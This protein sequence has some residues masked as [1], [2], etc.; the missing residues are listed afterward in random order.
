[1]GSGVSGNRTHMWRGGTQHDSQVGSSLSLNRR[2]SCDSDA[3]F[4]LSFCTSSL[5]PLA[6]GANI[7]RNIRETRVSARFG[8][9]VMV[10]IGYGNNGLVR[11][12]RQ[13]HRMIRRVT[14]LS[15]ARQLRLLYPFPFRQSTLA[16]ESVF[17]CLLDALRYV[18]CVQR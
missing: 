6:S 8:S 16:S 15:V 3:H 13:G 10:P 4:P 9:T 11:S 17:V 12:E 14:R 7:R 5:F 18:A 1:M 2:I